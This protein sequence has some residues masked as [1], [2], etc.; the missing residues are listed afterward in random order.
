MELEIPLCCGLGMVLSNSVVPL[1]LC[2][3]HCSLASLC[4]AS[5]SYCKALPL[6]CLEPGHLT[7]AC[8]S[9]HYKFTV[10]IHVQV[11]CHISSSCPAELLLSQLVT[12]LY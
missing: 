9:C 2:K 1:R 11:V 12:S 8:V 4:H 7:A 3:S 10:I 6:F 5:P